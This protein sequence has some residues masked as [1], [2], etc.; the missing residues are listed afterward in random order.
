MPLAFVYELATHWPRLTWLACCEAGSSSIHVIHGPA[1]ERQAEWFCEAVWDFPFPEGNFDQTDLVFGSGGRCRDAGV[2]FVSSG[3]TVDRLQ[4]AVRGNYTFVSNSLVCLCEA[5]EA[6]LDPRRQNYSEFFEIINQGIERPLPDLAIAGGSIRFIYHANIGWDGNYVRLMPKPLARRDFT[7]F[8]NYVSFMRSALLRIAENL[9]SP[10]RILPYFWLGT[11]S[12]GYDSPACAAL[13]RTAGLRRVIT[14]DES[15][16][17]ECDDGIAIASALGLECILVDRLAWKSQ[18][19]LEPLFLAADAQGKEIMIAGAAGELSDKV[20][21]TGH[22]GD[23]AWS[24]HRESCGE[25]L[26]RSVH[27]GLSMTEYR[28]HRG[29]IHLPV[30][31]MGLRQLPDIAKLSRSAE[32]K[33]WNIAGAYSRPICRRLIEEAG[34]PRELFGMSKTGASIRFLRGEDAWSKRGKR[35]FFRWL[36]SKRSKYEVSSQIWI[37]SQVCFIVLEIALLF[38]RRRSGVLRKSSQ[39]GSRILAAWIRSHRLND[40]AF[41]WAVETVRSSYRDA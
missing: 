5:V 20:L 9:S 39:R 31:F 22:G 28:L 32:M 34:V 19:L 15:R 30:P 24:M 12:R 4:I 3:S 2:I 35:A 14:H 7:R 16:P 17:G 25:F 27:S 33:P 8:D 26:A 40:L 10:E 36:K 6:Q 29:F 11:I 13:A 41:I 23:T 21:I 38:G 1:V 18:T 37:Q